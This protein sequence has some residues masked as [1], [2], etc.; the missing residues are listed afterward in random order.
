M[1]GWGNFEKNFFP[2][3]TFCCLH[4]HNVETKKKEKEKGETIEDIKD[5]T[6]ITR[7]VTFCKAFACTFWTE[8]GF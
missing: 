3:I 5:E 2:G 7:K 8:S 6:L 4:N 1:F